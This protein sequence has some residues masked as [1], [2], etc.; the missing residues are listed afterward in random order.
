MFYLLLWTTLGICVFELEQIFRGL[1][2]LGVV[3]SVHR[4]FIAPCKYLPFELYLERFH[5]TWTVW[6]V[7][8]EL[9]L[10]RFPRVVL[11]LVKNHLRRALRTAKTKHTPYFGVDDCL[12]VDLT[13]ICVKFL[14]QVDIF[15]A[16]KD[17]N[18]LFFVDEV[19]VACRNQ[20][21]KYAVPNVKDRVR[22][23]RRIN[24]TIREPLWS[25]E[26]KSVLLIA[27]WRHV[28]GIGCYCKTFVDERPFA[29]EDRR[30]FGWRI[31]CKVCLLAAVYSHN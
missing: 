22:V 2:N 20:L 26:L 17:R 10:A 1:Q 6:V 7:A 8:N 19:S 25:P 18:R 16:T 29:C 24:C 9:D 5:G 13:G 31:R 27:D 12:E 14:V 23:W 30:V 4:Y 21:S 3:V 15:T 11:L 28:V